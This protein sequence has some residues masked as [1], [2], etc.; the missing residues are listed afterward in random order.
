MNS[1]SV[2]PYISIPTIIITYAAHA[3]VVTI[4]VGFFKHTIH[5]ILAPT[6]DITANKLNDV[7][8]FP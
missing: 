2:P 1:A 7:P 3:T 4:L 5:A 6:I 8:L